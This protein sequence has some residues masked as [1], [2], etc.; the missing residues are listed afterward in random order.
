MATRVVASRGASSIRK[1]TKP[2]A[3]ETRWRAASDRLL[4]SN[5]YQLEASSAA[6]P[7]YFSGREMQH[8]SVGPKH[9]GSAYF[10]ANTPAGVGVF[11]P[12]LPVTARK[13][14]C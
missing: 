3:E 14:L 5:L 2:D 13:L 9:V 7:M 11:T 1:I 12:P 8:F 10:P 6:M 4:L